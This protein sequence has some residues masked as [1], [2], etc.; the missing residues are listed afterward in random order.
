MIAAVA[1]QDTPS[2]HAAF[3]GANGRIAFHSAT[4]DGN[5]AIYVSSFEGGVPEQLTQGYGNDGFSN[6]FD[7]AWSPDGSQLAFQRLEN[8]NWDIYVVNDDGANETRLTFDP[9]FDAYPAWSPDGKQLAFMSGRDSYGDIY[10]MN[11]DGSNVR[12]LTDDPGWDGDPAWSPDGTRIAFM[13]GRERMYP[14]GFLGSIYTM[15]PDGSD[16]VRRTSDPGHDVEPAWSPDGF[17]IAFARYDSLVRNGRRWR[18][19]TCSN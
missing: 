14:K 16:V 9:A 10:V 17:Q 13:S 15:A 2:A 12:R 18:Q 8:S 5:S 11:A 6:D 4:G 7:P 1:T 19:P 3:P